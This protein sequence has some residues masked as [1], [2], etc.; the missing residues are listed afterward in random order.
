MAEAPMSFQQPAVGIE[1]V[2][3]LIGG[4]LVANMVAEPAGST[5]N[6]RGSELA[7]ALTH[8]AAM[9]GGEI[10]QEHTGISK[11]AKEV[12][13]AVGTRL[14]AKGHRSSVQ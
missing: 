9:A 13:L 4:T 3:M 8:A 11:E 2:A 12:D 14:A 5:A 1:E 6:V 7:R 10:F